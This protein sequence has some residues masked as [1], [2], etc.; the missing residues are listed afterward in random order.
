MNV[1]SAYECDTLF[2]TA[3]TYGDA[4]Y[5]VPLTS[6]FCQDIFDD[7]DLIEFQLFIVI[8]K[9]ALAYSF[10]PYKMG[11]HMDFIALAFIFMEHFPTIF[12]N[13]YYSKY[14]YFFY[15]LM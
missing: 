5:N 2:F 7:F 12:R 15:Y 6:E 3:Q 14:F 8:L 1:W 4:Q 13:K 11:F 9:C 10:H